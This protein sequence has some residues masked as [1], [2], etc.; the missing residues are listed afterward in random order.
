MTD[1]KQ[2]RSHNLRIGRGN[3]LLVSAV[4]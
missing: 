4:Y 3:K 2:H 1:K